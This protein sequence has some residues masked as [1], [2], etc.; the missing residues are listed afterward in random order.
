M[1]VPKAGEKLLIASLGKG[2]FGKDVASVTLL[3]HTGAPI[4]FSQDEHALTV[5][6]PENMPFEAAIAF[7]VDEA[8]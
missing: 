2:A 5:T 6:C 1:T 8:G 3:G 7:K 4:E